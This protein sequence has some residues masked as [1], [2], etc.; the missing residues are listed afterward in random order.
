MNTLVGRFISRVRG[1]GFGGKIRDV[2]FDFLPDLTKYEFLHD[3]T[4][5]VPLI[6]LVLNWNRINQNGY[7]SS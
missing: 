5:I 2:G 4:L 1:E 7:I 3:V 6:L